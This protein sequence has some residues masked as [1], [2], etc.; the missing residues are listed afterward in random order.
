MD[1]SAG[2]CLSPARTP[3]L[4]YSTWPGWTFWAKTFHQLCSSEETTRVCSLSTP[5]QLVASTTHQRRY[6]QEL[7][8]ALA[9]QRKAK[10][11]SQKIIHLI[12]TGPNTTLSKRDW[13]NQWR[14]DKPGRVSE[15]SGPISSRRAEGLSTQQDF[16]CWFDQRVESDTLKAPPPEIKVVGEGSGEGTEGSPKRR[17]CMWAAG[18]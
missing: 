1:P 3:S 9:L 11:T 10:T 18:L 6:S 7:M 17:I 13:Y 12:Y 14:A 5:E 15:L 2:A 8:R 16:N 4:T